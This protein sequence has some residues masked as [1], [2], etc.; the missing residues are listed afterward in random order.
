MVSSPQSLRDVL[1]RDDLL[2]LAGEQFFLAGEELYTAQKI[3]FNGANAT[4]L[5]AVVTDISSS[6]EV[7][8]KLLRNGDIHYVCEC[9]AARAELFC[10]HCVACALVWLDDTFDARDLWLDARAAI[11][12]I[13]EAHNLRSKLRAYLEDLDR[14]ELIELLLDLSRREPAVGQEIL[15]SQRL[16]RFL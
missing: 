2:W 5:E 16:S 3:I 14:D 4:S 13:D 10:A 8:I 1:S 15:N 9:A 7:E 6:Y 11:S 12:E